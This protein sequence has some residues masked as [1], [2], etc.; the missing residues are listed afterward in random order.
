[1]S[2]MLKDSRPRSDRRVAITFGDPNGIGP[3]VALRGAIAGRWPAAWKRILVGDRATA[4]RLC[5]WLK[6]PR[7]PCLRLAD[8]IP[9][10]VSLWDP[11]G[12]SYRP[13]PG[14]IRADAARASLAWLDAAVEA[15]MG[16]WFDAVVTGPICKEGWQRAGGPHPGHTERLAE[17]TGARTFAMLL[18][19]GGLRVALATRHLPLARVPGALSRESIVETTRLVW[20]ALPWLGVPGGTIAVCALN[21][22][23][24][25]GGLLGDEEARIVRPAIQ[26]LRRRGAPVEGPVPAD[27]VFYRAIRG[28][29]AAVVALYHDQGLGPFKMVAFTTGVNV[30]L[31]LPIVR[32]SPD[33]G[34]AF[35]R[36]WKGG[37]EPGS[38]EAAIR[39]AFDLAG[40]PNPWRNAVRR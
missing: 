9:A 6:L 14:R 32:T 10:P 13:A 2:S 36:A 7:L 18:V 4:D 33:H 31:G 23:A 1:M 30:T 3:E 8:P 28:E 5:A 34:T 20:E 21:P 16:G 15:A 27:V 22:H 35:D 26:A 24:G 40:R 17:I 37:A 25:D 19:G 11:E 12:P 39:L 38:M 29:F